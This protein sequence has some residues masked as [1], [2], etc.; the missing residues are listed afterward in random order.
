MALIGMQLGHYTLTRLIGSG[1]MGEVYLAEDTRTHR[2]VAI[3][4]LRGELS[5]Y[6]DAHT[7][8]E[9]ERLFQREM[10]IITALDHPHILPLYDYGEEKMQ[11][12]LLTYMV[13]PYRP[14]GSLDDWLQRR[15]DKEPLSAQDTAFLLQQAGEALQCAH[16]HNIIHQDVKTSNFL[17]WEVKERP[18]RPNLL[19][20]DFGIAKT[21]SA[22]ASASQSVR[23]TPAYMPPE[24]WDGHP[25]Y[26]SDQYALAVMAYILLTKQ[27]PFSGRPEQVMRAHYFTAPQPPSALNPRLT[28]AIDAVILRALEKSPANRYPS[29]SAFVQALQQAV[30]QQPAHA[31]E[32]QPVAIPPPPPPPSSTAGD[33]HA[34]LTITPAEAYTGSMRSLKLPGGRTISVQVPARAYDQQMIRLDGMGEP[35][36][37]GG[38]AGAVLITLAVTPARRENTPASPFAD[39]NNMNNRPTEMASGNQRDQ[40]VALNNAPSDPHSGQ[41]PNAT[42]HPFPLSNPTP[43]PASAQTAK[44]GRSTGRIAIIAV[45]ALCA[46]VI[47]SSGIILF[48]NTINNNNQ[49]GTITPTTNP[50]T[51]HANATSTANA[52]GTGIAIANSTATAAA[53]ATATATFLQ[54]N[55][56]P[57]PPATGTISVVDPLNG[58]IT[59]NWGNF[60]DQ[61]G[62]ACQYS[63]GAYHI[64]E[65]QTNRFQYCYKGT[66]FSNFAF[67][68]QMRI[69]KGD[70][71]GLAFRINLNTN[72]MYRT[73]ICQNG[74]FDLY[75][76]D[77]GKYTTLVS[78]QSSSQIHQ[79]LGA[80]NTLAIVANGT[81]I[82]LF[83]NHTQLTS[84]TDTH[85]SSGF[86]GLTASDY[87]NATEVAFTNAR[88]WTL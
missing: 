77:N 27:R 69:I 23:G 71:G 32:E 25:V 51:A 18:N 46:V 87:T 86:L 62:G 73:E 61:Q 22:T 55:A 49:R 88:V 60:S 20:A 2:Q 31:L 16:D 9:A 33:L 72:Q 7:T 74:N 38:P 12:M 45:V 57:Y 81:T 84:I 6:T 26:A 28:P 70:C 8:Q 21:L 64:T 24:Q 53:Q 43:L 19:L 52:R 35:L 48:V 54:Q 29:I 1:G 36:Y 15:A 50:A 11:N 66:S 76:F 14:E 41:T 34:T 59:A 40:M 63:G 80:S 56:D 37:P 4:I 30:T 42:P 68:V 17:I 5:S 44:P 85:F 78:P 47:L 65:S 3:K 75:S 82:T 83:V 39:T 13:M 79:G 58:S 10:S 67:E